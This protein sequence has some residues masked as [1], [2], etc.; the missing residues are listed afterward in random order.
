MNYS[1]VI[2]KPGILAQFLYVHCTLDET[3]SVSM[4]LMI[5][6]NYWV[7]NS[8]NVG[9]KSWI[10]EEEKLKLPCYLIYVCYQPMSNIDLKNKRTNLDNC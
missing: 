6:Q 8:V 7:V 2:F 1:Q 9:R 3:L 5:V 10:S 4:C